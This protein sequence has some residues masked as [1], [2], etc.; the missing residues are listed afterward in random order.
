MD[1]TSA[2]C[3]AP[4]EKVVQNVAPVCA[5]ENN[6]QAIGVVVAGESEICIG[7]KEEMGSAEGLTVGSGTGRITNHK[8]ETHGAVS[9]PMTETPAAVPD[10][11]VDKS[12]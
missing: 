9:L 8:L 11:E 12:T 2:I 3:K 1:L 4:V 7:A 6:D 5:T 10:S